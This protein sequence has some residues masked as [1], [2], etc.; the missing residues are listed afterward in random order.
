MGTIRVS[1][2]VGTVYSPSDIIVT[3]DSTDGTYHDS[4][5]SDKS[6]TH[7]FEVEDGKE[8]MVHVDGT[9]NDGDET[10][11]IVNKDFLP[12]QTETTDDPEY[13]CFFNGEVN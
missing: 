3:V 4:C 12:S 7:D 11:I 6:F 10:V 8:Y 5:Q 2:E 13:A 9:N 1:V